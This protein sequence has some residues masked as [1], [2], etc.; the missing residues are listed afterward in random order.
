MK[1]KTELQ[2]QREKMKAWNDR[3]AEAEKRG[4][5][6]FYSYRTLFNKTK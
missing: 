4:L 1:K 3:R 2:Q 6:K 5:E